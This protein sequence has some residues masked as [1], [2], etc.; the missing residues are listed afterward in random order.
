MSRNRKSLY[1]KETLINL[2]TPHKEHLTSTGAWNQYSKQHNLPHS[3][4][5]IKYFGSWNEAK[6][7]F[8][9][10]Q[11]NAHRPV[12]YTEEELRFLLDQYHDKFSTINDWNVYASDNN[13]PSFQTFERYLGREWIEE[14]TGMV[15][16][17]NEEKL[18]KVIK[19]YFPDNP[20]TVVQWNVLAKDK[21]L[22]THMTIVRHFNSWAIMKHRVY[23]N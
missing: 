16:E 18:K 10:E 21:N 22:P 17:W 3:A 20:P 13:L 19:L 11:L 5:L 8:S 9:L 4:T 12:K 14:K 6:S 2:L 1:D 15:L 7:A 23:F